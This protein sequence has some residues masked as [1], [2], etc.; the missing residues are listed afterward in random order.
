VL[1]YL[2]GLVVGAVGTN[3]W[4]ELAWSGLVQTRLTARR[5]LFLGAALAAPLFAAVA[6]ALLVSS[7]AFRYLIGM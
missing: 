3:I 5:G 2:V 1:T 7:V 4:E 6:G